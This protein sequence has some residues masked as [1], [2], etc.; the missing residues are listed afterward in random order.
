MEPRAKLTNKIAKKSVL[1]K[2]K[3][4]G[5]AET[6]VPTVPAI[7]LTSWRDEEE[8]VDYE[9]EDPPTFSPA[10]DDYSVPE[11]RLPTP[12]QGSA[13]TS[14]SKDDLP[15]YPA[16]DAVMVGRKRRPNFPEEKEQRRKVARDD[17]AALPESDGK[18][19]DTDRDEVAALSRS[20]RKPLAIDRDDVVATH[21]KS[22]LGGNKSSDVRGYLSKG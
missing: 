21:P 14:P 12:E 6:R 20:G 1:N 10:E 2:G 17:V 19:L 15:A 13:N 11:D 3:T 18:T 7:D 8:R 22:S 4:A 9:P 16:E 5:Q